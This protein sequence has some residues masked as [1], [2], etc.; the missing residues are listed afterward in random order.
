MI[1]EIFTELCWIISRFIYEAIP[2]VYK[3]FD[4]F[5]NFRFF[6][7]DEVSAVW[8]NLYIILSVLVLFAIG[9]KLINSIIDPNVLDGGSNGKKKSAKYAF[10]DNSY[11]V[12]CSI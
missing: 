12:Y 2:A 6:S 3:V 11:N 7:E 10:F 8:N 1:E 9:I 4:F 5:A